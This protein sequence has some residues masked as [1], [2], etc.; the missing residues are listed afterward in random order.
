MMLVVLC[1]MAGPFAYAQK[2]NVDE[3]KFQ[4]AKGPLANMKSAKDAIDEAAVHERT[5]NS[6]EM[7][8]YRGIVYLKIVSE[9]PDMD[10]TLVDELA[11]AKESFI[12]CIELDATKTRKF[13]K[14]A[15]TNLLNVA[16]QYFNSGITDF[17]N[18][19]FDNAIV[20]FE[21]T[22]ELLAY[23]KNG[24]LEREGGLTVN[25]IDEQIANAAYSASD[26]E[27]AIMH[28]KML[29]DN[30]LA[31]EE[32]YNF[33]TQAY[34]LN[35]DTTNALD[36][37]TQGRKEIPESQ[38]LLNK[39]LD[40]Y[41]QMGKMVVLMEKLSAA[42]AEDPTNTVFLYARAITYEKTG[43]I[44]SAVADYDRIIEIDPQHFNAYYNKGVIYNNEVVRLNNEQIAKMA[45][46]S[47]S[48]EYYDG[49]VKEAY[50][51]AIVMFEYVFENDVEMDE[52]E[53]RSLAKQMRTIYAKLGR[54]DKF[55]EMTE[56]LKNN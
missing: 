3:A 45:Y 10:D 36:V 42:I 1:L 19:D 52:A 7:Y 21:I 39:E 43:E 40:I 54:M 18:R 14:D 17:N 46:D 12:K 51:K 20:K 48:I 47:K 34:L 11:I 24:I 27:K 55:D 31:S 15:E 22:K 28:Y 13:A 32:N 33:C 53:R 26:Y 49:K 2:M 56:W 6:P 4:L 50:S 23:D 25:K 9:Y 30:G 37:I 8:L 16:I 35:G 5:V 38:D 44:D 41:F 29:I